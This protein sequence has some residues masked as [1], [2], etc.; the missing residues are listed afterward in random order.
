MKYIYI[1]FLIGLLFLTGC[2]DILNV[3]NKSG[4]SSDAVFNDEAL[5]EAFLFNLYVYT[6]SDYM[7]GIN[8]N[9]RSTPGPFLMAAITDD[10][11]SKSGWIP[12][13]SQIIKGNISPTVNR[14]FEGN[15]W[16]NFYR[17]VRE[18]NTMLEGLAG[19]SF[20]E[21]FKTALTAETRWI[22]AYFYFELIRRYGDV[23]LL[24]KAQGLEDDL[25]VF[26]TP[27]AEVYQFI[28]DE[29]E[30]IADDL[31][32]IKD[33]APRD[34]ANREAAWAL[35]GR[36]MLYA[37]RFTESATL[38]RKLLT[39]E[40]PLSAN[41]GELFRSYGDDPEV[42]FEIQMGQAGY[43][44]HMDR[45]NWP[46]GYRSEAGG[47]TDPT[48]ELVDQYETIDGKMITDPT[49]IYNPAD[50][51]A[52]RDPRLTETI[53]Y[54]GNSLGVT[55][56]SG[57]DRVDTEFEVGRDG[58]RKPNESNDTQSGYYLKKFMDPSMGVNPLG[59]YSKV[60]YKVLRIG[61][62]L[63]NFA[64]AENEVN[65]PTSEVHAAINKIRNR[66]NV[67]MPALPLGLSQTEMREKIRHERRIELA[68][69]PHRWWDLLRWDIAEETLKGKQFHGMKIVRK[70]A[71]PSP[72]IAE[73][74]APDL[75]Y[76]PTFLITTSVPQVFFPH[77]K[78]WPIPQN[79]INKNPNLTQNPGY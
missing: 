56:K 75:N 32:S 2:T 3:E 74:D 28:Y 54:H 61:E 53:L 33:G 27:I 34:R 25:L 18:C 47:Q 46:V 76:D 62:A 20:S 52:N 60:S 44:T 37:E 57:I 71:A 8:G 35:N 23:P 36:A 9:T 1:R 55:P 14:G 29:L 21:E 15:T 41:Y 48:Q 66:A 26:R 16:R 7:G 11:R 68:F 67:N 17:A 24:T 63:L 77:F 49:S 51:Y 64:E 69:E 58:L 6:P 39:A 5:A 30:A 50:P 78:L 59:G 4:I 13:N 73:Y 31:P 65:G 70:T 42:L 72:Y 79:E 38:S 10:A 12:S 45:W 22:R 43:G 40:Y 19:S